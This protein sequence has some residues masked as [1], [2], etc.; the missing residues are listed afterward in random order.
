MGDG[1]T[2]TWLRITGYPR[3]SERAAFG[4]DAA[5]AGGLV[6]DDEEGPVFAGDAIADPLTGMAV[7]LLALACRS[8][9]G[10]WIA[11]VHMSGVSALAAA[12]PP[13]GKE[14]V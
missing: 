3:P 1:L 11:D 9:G 5:V 2:R 7:A 10:A 12:S 6:A 14:S 8:D 13:Y 4:D